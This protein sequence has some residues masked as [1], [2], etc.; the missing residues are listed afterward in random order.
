MFSGMARTLAGGDT[1]AEPAA[2]PAGEPPAAAPAAVVHTITFYADGQFT[3]D[4]GEPRDMRDPANAPFM[5]SIARGECPRELEPADTTTPVN[6]NLVRNAGAYEPPPKPAYTAFSG[7]SRTLA[8]PEPAAASAPEAPAAPP[9]ATAPAPSLG[10]SS[11]TTWPGPD[12]SQPVTSIQLRLIDGSRLVARFNLS[13]TVG[14]L[15]KFI[16][17]SRPDLGGSAYRLAVPFPPTQLTDDAATIQAAG[18][19][20]AVVVQKPA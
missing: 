19:Q 1:P 14:D 18:L 8:G 7:A 13:Q 4:D 16:A 12:E 20:N 5:N 2:E 6:V 3:V 17:A 10:G 15:R 9:A 11:A